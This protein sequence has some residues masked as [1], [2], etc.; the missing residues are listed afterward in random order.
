MERSRWVIAA[1]KPIRQFALVIWI[2]NVS[3]V[4]TKQGKA[5]PKYTFNYA[6]I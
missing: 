2:A 3:E 6:V 5:F 1:M 4:S